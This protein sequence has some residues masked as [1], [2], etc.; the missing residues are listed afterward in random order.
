MITGNPSPIEHRGYQAISEHPKT[1]KGILWLLQS[2]HLRLI[3]WGWVGDLPLLWIRHP[4]CFYRRAYNETKPFTA[5][6]ASHPHA[7]D[8]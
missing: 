1:Q 7:Q 4:P 2:T 3:D 5:D 6:G 8:W